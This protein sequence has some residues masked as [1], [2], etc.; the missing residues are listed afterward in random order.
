[1]CLLAALNVVSSIKLTLILWKGSDLLEIISSGLWSAAVSFGWLRF[2]FRRASHSIYMYVLWWTVDLEL[3]PFNQLLLRF[4]GRFNEMTFF[5]QPVFAFWFVWIG[6]QKI[7]LPWGVV[8]N[9]DETKPLKLHFS[10]SIT[11]PSVIW[12]SLWYFACCL[13]IERKFRQVSHW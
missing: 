9:Q 5:N 13:Q 8:C 12:F 1:M 11:H 2:W 3:I 6:L 4:G 10:F 7:L